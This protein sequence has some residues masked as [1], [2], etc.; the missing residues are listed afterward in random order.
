MEAIPWSQ[1][2]ASMEAFHGIISWKQFHW[3]NDIYSCFHGGKEHKLWHISKWYL[4]LFLTATVFLQEHKNLYI[5]KWLALRV[6][7][8][9]YKLNTTI[10]V[11]L[12]EHKNW[13]MS[14]W[15][16]TPSGLAI[17]REYFLSTWLRI[18][19]SMYIGSN[20]FMVFQDVNIYLSKFQ[21]QIVLHVNL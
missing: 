21:A 3:V 13:H 7:K 19:S 11:F 10:A 18:Y 17:A 2:Y 6:I 9:E 1:W 15:L 12:Q 14:K 16:S 5:F 20:V 8:Y 4:K